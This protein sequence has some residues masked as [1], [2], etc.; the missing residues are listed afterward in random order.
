MN[1][2]DLEVDGKPYLILTKDGKTELGVKGNTTPEKDNEEHKIV[3]PNIL[4]ITRKNA[5][6]LFVLRGAL[7]DSFKIMTAQELYDVFKYQWFEPLADN[8]RELLY[9]NDAN[10]V[11]DAYKVYSWEDIAKYALV[12]RALWSYRSN[13][14]GDWKNVH[15]GGDKFLLSLIENIP[16]WSDAV[17]QIPF[18]VGTYRA[19]HNIDATIQTGITWA[20]GKPWD[21]A[22]QNS[23]STNEYDNFFVLRGALYASKKFTY[24]TK[25][26]GKTYPA[27]E[28]VETSI[29]VNSSTLGKSITKEELDIYGIW[30]EK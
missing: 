15:D 19:F 13:G 4:I 9:V 30:S 10:Y 20:T 3:L 24:S 12:D 1:K 17:G 22:L 14:S 2:I 28:I 29:E 7:G 8:Y 21:A 5:D 6:V 18:A 11:M 23:D 25:V 27:V 26:T 16:Y